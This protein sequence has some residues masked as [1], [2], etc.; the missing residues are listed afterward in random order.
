MEYNGDMPPEK[1]SLLGLSNNP[2]NLHYHGVAV[3]RLFILAAIIM[4]IGLPFFASLVAGGVF[5]AV[6]GI[7][8]IGLYAGLTT[9]KRKW[10][11]WGDVVVSVLGSFTFELISINLY[12]TNGFITSYFVFN[13]ILALIFFLSLYFGVRTFRAMVLGQ[14]K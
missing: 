7:L 11:I 3:R 6:V 9:S 2:S 1:H 5:V 12:N 10:I 14:I 13:Q 8:V 4:L